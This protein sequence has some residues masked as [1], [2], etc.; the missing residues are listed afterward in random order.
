MAPIRGHIRSRGY[1]YVEYKDR[2]AADKAWVTLHGEELDGRKI[3]VLSHCSFNNILRSMSKSP[4]NQRLMFP[5]SPTRDRSPRLWRSP[6]PVRPQRYRSRSPLRRGFSSHWERFPVS[7]DSSTSSS[8]TSTVGRNR[9][10]KRSH[11]WS[12]SPSTTT[13]SWSSSD[14]DVSDYSS[15]SPRQRYRSPSRESYLAARPPIRENRQPIRERR[16]NPYR[17]PRRWLPW[18]LSATPSS[19]SSGSRTSGYD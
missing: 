5:K 18:R 13:G 3:F 8:M 6:R 11:D 10:A 12:R 2:E 9:H 4:D 15:R 17:I 14:S 1:A 19:P 7:S 16:R